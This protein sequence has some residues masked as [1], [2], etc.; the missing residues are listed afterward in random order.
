VDAYRLFHHLRVVLLV[1]IRRRRLVE[2]A[3]CRISHLR[4]QTILAVTAMVGEW[5]AKFEY[6]RAYRSSR[7]VWQTFLI[8]AHVV[9]I[10]VFLNRAP[11]PGFQRKTV[12]GRVQICMKE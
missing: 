1:N 7:H 2:S 9:Q 3:Q 11:A 4:R 6:E 10:S 5:I 12:K 8:F